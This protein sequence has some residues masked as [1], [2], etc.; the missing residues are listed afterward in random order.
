MEIV[1]WAKEM[2]GEKKQYELGNKIATQLLIHTVFFL[3]NN[4]TEVEIHA[5]SPLLNE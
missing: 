4:V 5:S 2:R 3:T 1:F